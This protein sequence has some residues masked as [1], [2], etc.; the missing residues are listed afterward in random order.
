MLF[1]SPF[2]VYSQGISNAYLQYID[3]YKDIAI[4]QQQE[5]GIPASITLAQGL[6][7]SGA[8]LSD[9]AKIANNHFGIKC[10]KDW[11]GNGFYQDDDEENECFRSYDN[12]MMSFEDHARF[13]KKKRYAV[14]FTF[15]VTDY[16][17]WAQGLKQCGYATD[18]A[19][20]DKLIGVIERY[21]LYQYD[22]NQPIRS[23]RKEL[24]GDETMEHS[25]EEAI[26]Q[27]VNMIHP[28]KRKWGLYYVV[29]KNLVKYND[30]ES[31]KVRLR[32][33]DIVYLEEKS[34]VA[35]IGSNF[36]IVGRGDNLR[37]ISQRYGMRLKSLLRLN[38]LHED[39]AI[40]IGQE[41]RLR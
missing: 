1:F 20:P 17:S 8:G 18:P 26:V 23:A 37:S 32:K 5:Y 24:K 7:E 41:L 40:E 33:G 19:Y 3:T 12:A 31:E 21:Q 35:P 14:L 9:L 39:D 22:T 34:K 6:L 16:K 27:E 11:T 29:A 15:D 4:L 38:D 28:M 36:H 2:F 25:I 10:H 30:Y 13:L